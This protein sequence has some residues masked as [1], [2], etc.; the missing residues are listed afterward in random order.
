MAHS[1]KLVILFYNNKSQYVEIVK[2]YKT[3]L[4][5]TVMY[6]TE[7]FVGKEYWRSRA[8]FCMESLFKLPVS[9]NF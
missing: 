7:K 3:N 2:Y 1:M 8:P 6:S 5:W 4:Y 9:L